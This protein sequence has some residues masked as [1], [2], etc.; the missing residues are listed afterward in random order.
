[1]VTVVATNM[2]VCLMP[3]VF[4]LHCEI[5]R[6]IACTVGILELFILHCSLPEGAHNNIII[7]LLVS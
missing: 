4:M 7:A 3:G 5:P 1:M 2:F 6:A